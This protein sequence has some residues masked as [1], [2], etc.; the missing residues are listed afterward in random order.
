MGGRLYAKGGP[1]LGPHQADPSF[2]PSTGLMVCGWPV[3]FSFSTRYPDGSSWLTGVYVVLLTK[4]D[5]FQ[6]Y[7]I[8]ILRDDTR[9]A[10]VAVH[11]PTATWHAY[12][13]FGGESLYVSSHGMPGGHAVKV[14]LDRP[15]TIGYGSGK[16]LF[17]EHDG[18]RWLENA[19][20]DVEYFATSDIGGSI[21]RLGSHRMY[22]TLAHD[23]YATMAEFDALEAML[24]AGTS[25]AFLTG[26]TLTWQIRY[27]DN[28]RTI[29]GYKDRASADPIQ[30]R[31]TTTLFRNRIVNRPENQITGVMSDGASND[32]PAD[33]VV[34]NSSHWVYAGT[35]LNNGSILP[36]L[37][38]YEW[39]HLVDNGF[40]PS[41]LTALASSVVPNN[42]TPG[43]R[44]EATLYERGSAFVFAASTIY[45]N[46]HLEDQPAVAQMMRNLLTRAGATAYK[47]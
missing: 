26:D 1:M 21:N 5:G 19:G 29:V 37:I 23:E 7:A 30:S 24:A 40:T 43:S 10:E 9:D 11:L 3:T 34:F 27:E 36:G 33:W 32:Q 2:D 45:F 25:L 8:F 38:F 47:P 4:N 12:N 35:G 46:Q 41:G 17:E 16:F 20:Y 31:F 42:V 28:E 44:H 13:D 18:I 39:D 22:I 15:I 14:S 6:T